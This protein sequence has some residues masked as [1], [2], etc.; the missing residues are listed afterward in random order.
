MIIIDCQWNKCQEVLPLFMTKSHS[1]KILVLRTFLSLPSSFPSL[2]F[3]LLPFP[4]S[5]PSLFFFSLS[6]PFIFSLV[7]YI[8]TLDLFTFLLLFLLIL[9]P[10]TFT[11]LFRPMQVFATKIHF[12]HYFCSF[13]S[14]YKLN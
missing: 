7:I 9:L 5:L 13:N 11:I 3:L 8:I 2:S 4:F 10:S 14:F 1:F 6:F 12:P